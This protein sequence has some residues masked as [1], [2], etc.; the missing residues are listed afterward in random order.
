MALELPLW[1]VIIIII[2]LV[3][4]AL[5]IFA[6]AALWVW[7]GEFWVGWAL[8]L[9]FLY[10]AFSWFIALAQW[11]YYSSSQFV[12]AISNGAQSAWSQ[13]LLIIAAIAFTVG[14]LFIIEFQSEAQLGLK[15]GY[16]CLFY[17][18]LELLTNTFFVNL[19]RA[20]EIAGGWWNTAWDY[21][22]YD[23][24]GGLVSMVT[25]IVDRIIENEDRIENNCFYDYKSNSTD[26]FGRRRGIELPEAAFVPRT[27]PASYYMERHQLSSRLDLNPLPLIR[28]FFDDGLL[29]LWDGLA[30]VFAG[31]GEALQDAAKD[32]DTV[33][34]PEV[35]S[36]FSEVLSWLSTF[37][38]ITFRIF[39]YLC[40]LLTGAIRSWSVF[41]DRTFGKTSAEIAAED[42]PG[43]SGVTSENSVI[44][45]FL[46]DMQLLL[47]DAFPTSIIRD[48]L[49]C[50]IDLTASFRDF[51]KSPLDPIGIFLDVADFLLCVVES[52]SVN[53]FE[54]L[55][56]VL[57]PLIGPLVE[58][59]YAIADILGDLV[60]I[61]TCTAERFGNF[62]NRLRRT[63]FKA[64]ANQI[65][66]LIK[67][68][69]LELPQTISQAVGGLLSSIGRIG[70]RD[71][72]SPPFGDQFGQCEFDGE[73]TSADVV[74]QVHDVM[75]EHL[76]S[77]GVHDRTYCGQTLH[78]TPPMRVRN[79]PDGLLMV[80]P[81]DM[82]AAAQYAGCA[83]ALRTG[84]RALDTEHA[85]RTVTA[86]TAQSPEQHRR[87]REI[88][89][90]H[91]KPPDLNHFLSW[92]RG[93]STLWRG[94]MLRAHH[95]MW[96]GDDAAA[97][98][99]VDQCAADD[100]AVA[101][102]LHEAREA[103]LRLSATVRGTPVADS[104]L[105][106]HTGRWTAPPDDAAKWAELRRNLTQHAYVGP[107]PDHGGGMTL[108][109]SIVHRWR[110]LNAAPRLAA[111]WERACD[112][113]HDS[114]IV[115]HPTVQAW[116]GYTRAGM[117]EAAAERLG[118]DPASDGSH[119]GWLLPGTRSAM[120]GPGRLEPRSADEL[121]LAPLGDKTP[122]GL[123]AWL[124][125]SVDV[126]FVRLPRY[127]R[128]RM[129]GEARARGMSPD[130][131][132]QERVDRMAHMH[133][134][135]FDDEYRYGSAER[136]AG[137]P[138]LD[139]N[140]KN[141]DNNANTRFIELLEDFLDIIGFPDI[142]IADEV[143]K[144]F[145][146]FDF[147]GAAEDGAQ[148][149]I[150]YALCTE[151]HLNGTRVYSITC[152]PRVPVTYFNW[153]QR[154]PNNSSFTEY[155]PFP[156]QIESVQKPCQCPTIKGGGSVLECET[157][158]TDCT[159]PEIGFYD[160]MYS[161][162]YMFASS[163]YVYNSIALGGNRTVLW[164]I[165]LF[166]TYFG[167]RFPN[168]SP[169]LILAELAWLVILSFGT[170]VSNFVLLGFF[171]GLG[172][173][174]LFFWSVIGTWI[175]PLPMGTW[176]GVTFLRKFPLGYDNLLT[177]FG[178]FFVGLFFPTQLN[179]VAYFRRIFDR[180]DYIN[181]GLTSVPR[182]DT[183]CFFVMV[184][185]LG[186]LVF[187][188]F[189]YIM[190]T[191]YGFPLLVFAY[192]L[193]INML[194]ALINFFQWLWATRQAVRLD[195]VVDQTD[196]NEDR[197]EQLRERISNLEEGG[198][199]QRGAG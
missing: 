107:H 19:A 142:D 199:E 22:L 99:A 128:D 193:V 186:I 86:D 165:L 17:P 68:C 124:T 117:S 122:W 132:W 73:C 60:S 30:M 100:L 37:I 71:A 65:R 170:S 123:R 72:T 181:M 42:P 167:D 70:L 81:T 101:R 14:G 119:H 178:R 62:V 61:F 40:D 112:I 196:D 87:L 163:T 45:P 146:D 78:R 133:G 15:V 3:I 47:P 171:I 8:A 28:Q 105:H 129:A 21:I 141:A 18:V 44:I 179:D 57:E 120:Y 106:R 49:G 82:W 103:A 83:M 31:A 190:S 52:L 10:F 113:V 151:E 98:P 110:A 97:G 187:W 109:E 79:G 147:V 9:N 11:A 185:S 5:A 39:V 26:P 143:A 46:Q 169:M 13:R 33:I 183:Y 89:D 48:L 152:V 35:L 166:Q 118:I 174:P 76:W 145:S 51:L 114:Q 94:L 32:N 161:F 23:D 144:F 36:A 53:A 69:L 55:F 173:V 59:L 95:R 134:R 121:G 150:D 148:M 139:E 188:G 191:L 92:D 149:I 24:R 172:P 162:T 77:L 38:S 93:L 194:Y 111:I 41:I 127:I 91:P 115:Y 195:N 84:L 140:A 189:I 157:D 25:C 75:R 54:A 80:E 50:F 176:N 29:H 16:D 137:D 4:V 64:A 156:K 138:I 125:R 90:T 96:Y 159:D 160:A 136:Q 135:S 2:Q 126:M 177:N 197:I 1:A 198:D 184:P 102:A 192:Q 131:L 168:S 63:K 56:A 154:L 34:P 12:S 7:S 74:G 155:L 67:E 130:A 27:K 104:R 58:V 175:S 182:A 88:L 164:L 85:L 158:F 116:L 66:L 20:Y 153:V 43:S 108:G 180:L 6:G